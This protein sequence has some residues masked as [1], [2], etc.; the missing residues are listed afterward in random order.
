MR[1]AARRLTRRGAACCGLMS[2]PDGPE[3]GGTAVPLALVS[4]SP[5]LTTDLHFLCFLA[6]SQH[7]TSTVKQ[8]IDD[9][10]LLPDAIVRHLAF[11]IRSEHQQD[12]SLDVL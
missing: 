11:P 7:Q 12:R 10:C 9:V 3:I 6:C 8:P 5:W 2:S 4:L 1:A